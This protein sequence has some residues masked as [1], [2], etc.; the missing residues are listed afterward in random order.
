MFDS[1][2]SESIIARAIKDKKIKVTFYNPRDFTNDKHKRVDQKPYAGGPGMVLEAMPII[3]AAQK[4]IGRKKSSKVF[5]LSA[6]GKQFDTKAAEAVS[7]SRT[8]KDIVLI[9]GRYEGIDARVKKALKATE[10]SIG[11]YVLTGGELPA[12]VVIDSVTRRIKG[13][14]GDDASVEERRISTHEVYTRPA[15][16]AVGGKKYKVPS[17]LISGDHK[18]IEEWKKKRGRK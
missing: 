13:V 4:A 7:H 1:Y 15:E 9:C 2:L 10:L 16:I 3:K 14:L 17:V 12:M 6:G 11:P 18:K 5:I 8:I